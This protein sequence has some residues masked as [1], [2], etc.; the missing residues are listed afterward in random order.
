MAHG[1]P[2]IDHTGKIARSWKYKTC[3]RARKL[4]KVMVFGTFDVL[5]PGHLYFLNEARKLGNSLIVSV[6]R[7]INVKRIKGVTPLL[8]EQDRL[9]LLQSLRPVDKA[10]LGDRRGY[11]KHVQKE[12]PD[13]I[14]LGYDQTAYIDELR[15]DIV[16]GRLHV[17]LVHLKAFKPGRHKSRIYKAR[18]GC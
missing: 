5:H 3:M 18:M 14:A 10:V 13:I 11:L 8:P 7:D 6:A 15:I 17:K 9:E 2:K 16:A 1:L 12:D 4:K